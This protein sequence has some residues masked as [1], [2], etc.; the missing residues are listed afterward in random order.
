MW[1]DD[2]GSKI[3]NQI[4]VQEKEGE[5][6]MNP[7]KARKLSYVLIGV[8]IAV[9][10]VSIYSGY[11]MVGLVSLIVGLVLVIGLLLKYWKCPDCKAYFPLYMS[12]D[13]KYCPQCGKKLQ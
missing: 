9:L 5:N 12:L 6:G 2:S 3:K 13:A 4:N 1:Y 7:F 8:S 10:I 11:P